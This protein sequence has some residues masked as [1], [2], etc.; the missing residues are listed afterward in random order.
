MTIGLTSDELFFIYLASFNKRIGTWQSQ[1]AAAQVGESP[2]MK[3]AL[4]N[5]IEGFHKMFP[6]ITDPAILAGFSLAFQTVL[7]SLMDS[8]VAN[9][10]ELAKSIPHIERGQK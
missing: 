3:K 9:N 4:D 5:T 2:E 10:G 1:I 6:N 7:L 8:V